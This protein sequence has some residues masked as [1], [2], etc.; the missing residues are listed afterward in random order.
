MVLKIAVKKGF[1]FF[2]IIVSGPCRGRSTYLRDI[3]CPAVGQ[4]YLIYQSDLVRVEGCGVVAVSVAILRMVVDIADEHL[5]FSDIAELLVR[6]KAESGDVGGVPA[7]IDPRSNDCSV[8]IQGALTEHQSIAFN[9]AFRVQCG[10]SVFYDS[11]GLFCNPLV[12]RGVVKAL[13]G[14]SGLFGNDLRQETI[15]VGPECLEIAIQGNLLRRVPVAEGE[16]VQ[17][18]IGFVQVHIECGI[19]SKEFSTLQGVRETNSMC[20]IKHALFVLADDNG[21]LQVATLE[22]VTNELALVVGSYFHMVCGVAGSSS[23]VLRSTGNRGPSCCGRCCLSGIARG[24]GAAGKARKA[25]VAGGSLNCVSQVVAVVT[26]RDCSRG[27]PCCLL[28]RG[29]HTNQRTRAGNIVEVP[30]GRKAVVARAGSGR[31]I[32]NNGTGA[33]VHGVADAVVGLADDMSIF[34]AV[35]DVVL[36]HSLAG[37]VVVIGEPIRA[38]VRGCE[39]GGA[40][41]NDAAQG[42]DKRDQ[43]FLHGVT[44]F[45]F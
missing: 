28:T 45:L 37:G 42:Q 4:D 44:S 5:A 31:R 36:V 33:G 39:S 21:N 19:E 9:S 13:Q 1:V 14:V 20:G 18:T 41:P 10:I 30:V 22:S 17:S 8:E 40:N 6:N 26:K 25:L 24:T 23:R 43:R 34:P 15:F 32:G 35:V 11:I 16:T 3:Q 29:I 12:V 2:Y 38:R 27:V 7:R